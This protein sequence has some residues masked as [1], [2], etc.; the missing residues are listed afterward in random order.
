MPASRPRR[1]IRT[2]TSSTSPRSTMLRIRAQNERRR[3]QRRQDAE[4]SED[5]GKASRPAGSADSSGHTVVRRE[6]CCAVR[7]TAL[8][9]LCG[10]ILSARDGKADPQTRTG[11]VAAEAPSMGVLRSGG[12]SAG[13]ARGRGARSRSERPTVASSAGAP[14]VRIRRSSRGCGAG[15]RMPRSGPTC[16][17][18]GWRARC[19]RAH[20]LLPEAQTVRLVHAESDGL[21]GRHRR[22]LRRYAWCC[23]SPAPVRS[24]WR[25]TLADLLLELSA[26]QRVY[27]RSDAEV[28]ALEGMQPRVGAAARR[29]AARPA[30]DRR[31]RPEVLGQHRRRPQDRLLSGPARQPAAGAL[32]GGRRRGAGL[33]LLHG[34]VHGQRARRGRRSRDRRGG[35]RRGAGAGARRIW[36]STR[37]RRSAANG[38]KPTCSRSCAACATRA[39]GSI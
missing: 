34:R 32:A 28:L 2:W 24:A 36:R 14:T 19:P 8:G 21:P 10:S 23:S 20:A 4:K 6:P 22:P 1:C 27:E 3:P 16:C 38:W 15:A 25:E 39:G 29:P 35:V 13:R 37:W 31:G 17:A 9:V 7:C 33:L 12:A 26:A 11:E 30:R 5:A 18:S